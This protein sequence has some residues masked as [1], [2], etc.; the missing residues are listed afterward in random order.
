MRSS[1]KCWTTISRP[2]RPLPD[3][4]TRCL[5]LGNLGR[6]CGYFSPFSCPKTGPPLPDSPA[7]AMQAARSRPVCQKSLGQLSPYCATSCAA[8]SQSRI[9]ELAHCL[10]MGR[11]ASNNSCGRWAALVA[12]KGCT[13]DS[14]SA[15]WGSGDGRLAGGFFFGSRPRFDLPSELTKVC[16]R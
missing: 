8:F 15:R 9:L 2:T 6:S 4:A 11:S 14:K 7:M 16:K 1:T 5:L 12:A 3:F 13:S 10:Q